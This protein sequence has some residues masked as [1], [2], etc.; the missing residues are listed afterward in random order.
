MFPN[1]DVSTYAV[2]SYATGIVF[3]KLIRGWKVLEN[4]VLWAIEQPKS[5]TMVEYL[6]S[7]AWLQHKE[8]SD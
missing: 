2:V 3:S 5:V 6:P 1:M 4:V 8:I 7:R